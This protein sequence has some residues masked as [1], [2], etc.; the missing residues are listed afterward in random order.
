M[1]TAPEQ[2]SAGYS[3][4][5]LTLGT[6]TEATTGRTATVRYVGW[7]YSVSAPDHKGGQFDAGTFS[8]TIGAHSVIQGFEMAVNGMKVGGTRRAVIPPS[9]AYG[10]SGNP[11]ANIGPDATLVFDIT[12]IDLQ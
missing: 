12:L 10:T 11:A 1:P 2:S 3:T 8:F 4:N 7:L 6:G 9:L 5:D